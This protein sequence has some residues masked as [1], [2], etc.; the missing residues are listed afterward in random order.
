MNN[1]KHYREKAGLSQGELAEKT[2]IEQSMISRAELG[3]RDLPGQ[4]WKALA[5]A[6]ECSIDELLGK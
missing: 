3:T 6:L 1:L 5:K 4:K 2:G